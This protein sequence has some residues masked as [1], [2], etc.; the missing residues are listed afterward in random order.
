MLGWLN[1]SRDY[2]VA[3]D[4]L[5]IG[6]PLQGPKPKRPILQL[7]GIALE[8]TMKADL[9]LLGADERELAKKYGHRLTK[10]FAAI[11]SGRK[12]EAIEAAKTS[13]IEFVRNARDRYTKKLFEDQGMDRN[14]IHMPNNKGIAESVPTAQPLIDEL[15][16]L[17][18]SN[19]GLKYF[20]DF[21]DRSVILKFPPYSDIPSLY[22]SIFGRK[23]SDRI[24]ITVRQRL[25]PEC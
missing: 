13:W 25:K 17:Y 14:T 18:S 4:A 16:S 5:N 22:L 11:D 12:K 15:A 19:S 20:Q 1:L 10:L 23:L 9:L 8:T 6:Q 21:Y 24:E 3:I 2:Y 7:L